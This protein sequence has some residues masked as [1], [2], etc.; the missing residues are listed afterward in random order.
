MFFADRKRWI[1]STLFP[2]ARNF[3]S[4]CKHTVSLPI[5]IV[6]NTKQLWYCYY[7][8]QRLVVLATCEFYWCKSLSLSISLSAVS[9]PLMI[10]IMKPFDIYRQVQM[11]PHHN[12][13]ICNECQVQSAKFLALQW[14]WV[15][16]E[17][18]TIPQTKLI[19]EFQVGFLL[20]W[21]KI[22]QNIP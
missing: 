14:E 17:T 21:I 7:P 3:F 10:N 8:H 13:A 5:V 15:K 20:L 12:S 22:N 16:C 2:V 6:A 18:T 11:F 4:K 19:F 1:C 9:P